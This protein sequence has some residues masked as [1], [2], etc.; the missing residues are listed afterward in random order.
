MSRHFI[1]MPNFVRTDEQTERLARLRA[2]L[3]AYRWDECDLVKHLMKVNEMI[4]NVIWN[5]YHMSN[6]EMIDAL[7]STLPYEWRDVMDD[8]WKAPEIEVVDGEWESGEIP[9]VPKYKQLA[10][11][12]LKEYIRVGAA[13]TSTL[14]MNSSW[15]RM[16]APWRNHKGFPR[17]YPWLP[18]VTLEFSEDFSKEFDKSFPVD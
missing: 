18:N 4:Q 6:S 15:R 16:N 5:G 9:V 2:E 1:P 11:N 17:A 12:F 3:A 8:L 14:G 10:V 7:R 13:K